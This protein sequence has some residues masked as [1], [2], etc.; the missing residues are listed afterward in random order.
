MDWYYAEGND[1]QGPVTEAEFNEL[2]RTGRVTT[3]TQVWRQGWENWRSWGEAHRESTS[4]GAGRCVQCGR[5][6]PT[7]EMVQYEGSSVCPECKPVFFQKIKEGIEP[8][9]TMD[10]AGFW[11]R[12]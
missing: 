2:V 12:F 10:Y 4:D 6:F 1:R 9:V 11:I 3:N 8:T 5:A 7:A